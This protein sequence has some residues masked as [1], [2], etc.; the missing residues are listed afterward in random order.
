[1]KYKTCI[2]FLYHKSHFVITRILNFPFP[3]KFQGLTVAV[4]A[5]PYV[6]HVNISDRTFLKIMAKVCTFLNINLSSIREAFTE[7]SV[8]LQGAENQHNTTVL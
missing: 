7:I 4:K 3:I 6:Q 5:M 1:M 2:T 8:I